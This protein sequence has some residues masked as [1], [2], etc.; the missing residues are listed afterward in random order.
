VR[1]ADRPAASALAH[2]LAGVAANMAIP[3]TFACAAEVERVLGQELDPAL[4]LAQ[5]DAAMGLVLA[6]IDRLARS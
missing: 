1:H 2:K 6:A 5:L 4:P 3:Q